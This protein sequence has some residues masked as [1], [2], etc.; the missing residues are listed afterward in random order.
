MADLRIGIIG[1]GGRMGQANI[2]QATETAGCVVVAASDVPGSP[3]IGRDA[4]EVSGIG[5]LGVAI[6]GDAAAVIEASDA[7]IEFTLPGPTV[8][9][10]E[11]TAAKGV[12]HVIGTTGLDAR[13]ELR[14]RA[15]GERT[16]IM[17]APNMSLAVNLL[18]ALTKQVART[19]DDDFDIEIFEMH[20]KH[21]VDAPSGT[22]VGLGRAA[23]EGRGI[24]LDDVARWTRHGQTGARRRG[25]IGFAAL[26]G[27]DVVGDHSVIFAVE[28]ERLELTHKAQSRQIFA[29]GAVHAALWT[30]G[31]PPGFYSMFDVLGIEY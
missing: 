8:D 25:D 27:G 14:L 1:A 7:V 28:G 10:A 23:A 6:S 20:H 11:M 9:H 3:L 22:A 16:A 17:H 31:K 21:K 24:D 5:A 12:A 29:R 13:Q 4:G 2:R 30:R 19:L 15:A 26:R 18:F